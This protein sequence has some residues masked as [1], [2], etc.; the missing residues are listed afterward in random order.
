[1][2]GLYFLL[3]YFFVFLYFVQNVMLFSNTVPMTVKFHRKRIQYNVHLDSTVDTYSP[4][5]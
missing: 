5:L 1:M 2:G 4:V 3:I